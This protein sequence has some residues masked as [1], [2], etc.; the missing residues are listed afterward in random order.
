MR[1]LNGTLTV[2]ACKSLR[3]NWRPLLVL[4]VVIIALYAHPRG[5]PPHQIP[6]MVMQ[7]FAGLLGLGRSF[8][9]CAPCG[10]NADVNLFRSCM[11]DSKLDALGLRRPAQHVD[12]TNAADLIASV[13]RPMLSTKECMGVEAR[14]QSELLGVPPYTAVTPW[15]W[16][17]RTDLYP[18]LQR[19]QLDAIASWLTTQD[20]TTNVLIMWVPAGM[21]PP[22][23]LSVYAKLFPGVITWRALDIVQEARDT[24]FEHSYLIYL[25]D[26]KAYIDG[27]IARLTLLYK[28]GGFWSDLDMY[29]LRDLKP[30]TAVEFSMEFACFRT[31]WA[32]WCDWN[33]ALMHYFPRGR[34]IE[35]LSSWA[36]WRMPALS[37]GRYGPDLLHD[38]HQQ[39][40]LTDLAMPWCFFHALWCDQGGLEMGQLL[41]ETPWRGSEHEKLLKQAYALHVHGA[42]V[43]GR[44]AKVHEQGMLVYMSREAQVNLDKLLVAKYGAE[45]A[46]VSW[47]RSVRHGITLCPVGTAGADGWCRDL[48]T[49]HIAHLATG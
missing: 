18:D 45:H 31:G 42:G 5:T 44:T 20:L 2:R 17:V 38:S 9:S 14:L 36:L 7:V 34:N 47:F 33:G 6:V 32:A 41:A 37:S 35:L 22:P 12:N 30:L 21:P 11:S 40:G 26:E 25:H 46:L 3:A 29:Y 10:C 24:P 4:T 49:G 16:Y 13:V 1:S 15:H 27:D 39:P 23:S 8:A 43:P 19:A 28:Y 48:S